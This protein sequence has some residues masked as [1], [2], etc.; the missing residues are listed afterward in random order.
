MR[1]FTKRDFFL[2]E[3]EITNFRPWG[4]KDIFEEIKGIKQILRGLGTDCI[5][6]NHTHPIL[7]FPVVRVVIPGI[8]DFLPFLPPDILTNEKTKPSTAWK[9][10]AFK[11]IMQSF[12][13]NQ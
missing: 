3:G 6:L 9:G 12:F 4:K 13:A 7:K 11:E 8:S 1:D 2:N 5:L 10:E